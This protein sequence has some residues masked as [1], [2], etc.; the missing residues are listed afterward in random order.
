[1]IELTGN[2]KVRYQIQAKL[3]NNRKILQ[4]IW[5]QPPMSR[6]ELSRTIHMNKSTIT[7]LVNDLIDE[8]LVVE[9]GNRQAGVGRASTMLSLNER[10]GYAVAVKISTIDVEVAIGNIYANV[11]WRNS[12]ITSADNASMALLEQISALIKEGMQACG[13]NNQDIL[14]IGVSAPSVVESS[15]GFMFATPSIN[16][17][18]IPLGEYFKAVFDRPVYVHSVSTNA[19]RAEKWYGDTDETSNIACVEISRG[20]GIG[21]IING[22]VYTG[23]KGFAGSDA[24]HMVL[25]PNGPLCAC[26]KRGCWDTVGSGL[27][28]GDQTIQQVTTLADKGDKHAIEQLNGI[29]KYI[30]IGV[31]NIVK[32]LNPERVVVSGPITIAK[33]WIYNPMVAS[34]RDMLWAHVLSNTLVTFS[35]LGLDAPILG[36]LMSVLEKTI[37]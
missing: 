27:A 20:V 33:S 16:L 28:L 1:M 21:L 29:G 32:I 15:S 36:S 24:A 35:P 23:S 2:D 34:L 17:Y 8:G 18:N 26:G 12:F 37:D 14:G 11:L 4:A 30:G 19:A 22:Q 9:V 5:H 6:S 7:N 10:Y 3:D 13:I 31:A 25:D